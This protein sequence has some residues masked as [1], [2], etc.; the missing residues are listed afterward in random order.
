VPGRGSVTCWINQLLQGDP[1]AA[2]PLW[3]RYFHLL[4]RRAR[5]RLAG[6]PRRA[7]D[8]EDVALSAFDSFCRAAQQKRFPRLDD[9]QD[10]WQLLLLLTDRKVI[11]QRRQATRAR[12]GGGKALDEAALSPGDSVGS[13]SPLA[14]LASPE[15]SP[16]FA[17]QAAENWRRLLALLG[18]PE[19]EKVALLK[20]EGYSLADIAARLGCVPRTVQRRLRLIRHIWEREGRL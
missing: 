9:R 20:M 16:E 18:D 14:G 17:A 6:T 19:L 1:A 10:L 5:H 11:D 2:R 8:E 13:G 12:R 15:P 3:E 4:A 7:A